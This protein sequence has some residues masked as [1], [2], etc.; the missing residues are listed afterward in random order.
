MQKMKPLKIKRSLTNA[1][2]DCVAHFVFFSVRRYR[3]YGESKTG[4]FKG[5][6]PRLTPAPARCL[7]AVFLAL[8][9]G[10]LA[11]EPSDMERLGAS[12]VRIEAHD[13]FGRVNSGTGIVVAPHTLITNCHVV[14]NARIIDATGATG[15]YAARLVRAHTVRDLC[16]LDA[17]GLE[18][19]AINLGATT[20]KRAGDTISAVGYPAGSALTWSHGKIEGL[21]PVNGAGRVVQGSAIFNPGA[22]GGGLFDGEGRLIGVLTFKLRASGPYHFAV[23]VEWLVSLMQQDDSATVPVFADKPFW[24]HTDQRQPVF[25]RAASLSADGDCAGLNTLAAQ[26]LARDPKHAETLLLI[27]HAQQCSA[28]AQARRPMLK[29]LFAAL[30]P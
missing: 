27:R 7:F 18:A 25:L 10:A 21:F 2:L 13:G 26:R 6:F 24:Q 30:L 11:L 14:A 5:Q 4:L 28:S 23:P 17:P 22:S 9:A 3:Q 15:R 8:P 29:W 19:A 16:L 1:I 20:E 12:I